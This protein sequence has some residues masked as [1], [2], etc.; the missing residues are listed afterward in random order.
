MFRHPHD[1]DEFPSE[2]YVPDE[3]DPDYRFSEVAG[4]SGW[5]EPKRSWARPLVLIVSFLVL[6]SLTLPLAIRF[7]SR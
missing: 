5:E 1:D 6:A 3:D 4:Y 2:P 7:L